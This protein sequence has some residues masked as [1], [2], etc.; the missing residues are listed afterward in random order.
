[1]ITFR[2]YS[3]KFQKEV[4]N[5]DITLYNEKWQF[6]CKNSLFGN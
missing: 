3:I 5:Q 4:A 1:M 6:T 2:D